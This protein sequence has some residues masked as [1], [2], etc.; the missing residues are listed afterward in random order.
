MNI[1][2]CLTLTDAQKAK[3]AE[4]VASL[5]KTSAEVAEEREEECCFSSRLIFKCSDTSIGFNLSVTDEISGLS[6][7]LLTQEDIDNI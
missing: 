1:P 2:S 5:P 4:F 3:L 7:S 6:T